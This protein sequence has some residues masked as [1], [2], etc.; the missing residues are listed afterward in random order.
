MAPR[1]CVYRFVVEGGAQHLGFHEAAGIRPHIDGCDRMTARVEPEKTM[2]ECRHTHPASLLGRP[3]GMDRIQARHDGFEES[4]RVVLDAAVRGEPRGVL[5][6]VG[7]PCDRPTFAVV[8]R[9]PRGR[10]ADVE[11]D[12]H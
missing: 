1:S 9:G 8:K 10:G 2:P 6:L 12:D 3:I 11:R 4:L 7:A 5:H